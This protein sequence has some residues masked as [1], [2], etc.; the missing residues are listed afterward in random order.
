MKAPLNITTSR[1]QLHPFHIVESSPWPLVASLG[2]FFTMFGF[3][4][5][6]HFYSAG[7]NVFLTGIVVLVCTMF[8][9]W[10]DVI[11]E[12]TQGGHHTTY[13]RKGLRL[14][15]RKSVV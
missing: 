6:L 2:A 4:L 14:G 3:G 13:V 12:G 1:S 11:R 9:W 7:Y 8:M 5:Y 15:D 10:R